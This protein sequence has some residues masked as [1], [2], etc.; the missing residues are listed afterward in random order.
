MKS[1]VNT[2]TFMFIETFIC[3][4]QIKVKCFLLKWQPKEFP[5]VPSM[6]TKAD[7]ALL[8]R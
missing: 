3:C 8:L 5:V 4:K 6:S 1:M 2:N 7:P